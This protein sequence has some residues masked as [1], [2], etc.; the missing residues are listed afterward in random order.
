MRVVAV[1]IVVAKT[2]AVPHVSARSR[3]QPGKD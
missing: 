1:E 2:V 3:G